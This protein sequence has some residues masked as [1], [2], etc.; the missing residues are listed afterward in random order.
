MREGRKGSWGGREGKRV[1]CWGGPIFVGPGWGGRGGGSSLDAAAR[2]RR[3]MAR[4]DEEF[5]RS[6]YKVDAAGRAMEGGNETLGDP[7]GQVTCGVR[8]PS[9][10]LPLPAT[11]TTHSKWEVV[12]EVDMAACP[13]SVSL[14]CEFSSFLSSLHGPADSGDS[15]HHGISFSELL[16]LV[17]PWA[18]HRLPFEKVGCQATQTC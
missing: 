3:K 8:S 18:G 2:T 6:Q 14:S 12:A 16:I 7:G 17:E 11:T 5:A 13:Y 10:S 15:G 1:P 9:P 4:G